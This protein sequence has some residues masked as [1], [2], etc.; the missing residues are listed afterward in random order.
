MQDELQRC[1]IR[2]G[3]LLHA[4][5]IILEASLLG[6]RRV[7]RIIAE[8]RSWALLVSRALHGVQVHGQGVLVALDDARI[9]ALEVRAGI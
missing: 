4:V 3:H 5:L 6:Q 1:I 2:H 7:R 8:V 9:R